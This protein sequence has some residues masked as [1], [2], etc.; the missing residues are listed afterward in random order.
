VPVEARL[1]IFVQLHPLGVLVEF[2]EGELI[3][4]LV[5]ACVSQETAR[6]AQF[7]YNI[8]VDLVDDLRV[9][10]G[11]KTAEFAFGNRGG[12]EVEFASHWL[13]LSMD[14]NYFTIEQMEK[15]QRKN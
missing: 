8:K 5:D 1:Q 2:E 10:S 11:E 9:E 7:L 4:A 15:R 12:E 3:D 6:C 13:L 14:L